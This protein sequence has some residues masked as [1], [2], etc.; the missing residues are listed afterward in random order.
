MSRYTIVLSALALSIPSCT[1]SPAVE[2]AACEKADDCAEGLSCVEKVCRRDTGGTRN[3]GGAEAGGDRALA[4]GGIDDRDGDDGTGGENGDGGGGDSGSVCCRSR[5]DCAPTKWCDVTACTC[6]SMRTCYSDYECAATF[7]CNPYRNVCECYTNDDCRDWPGGKTWCSNDTFRCEVPGTPPCDLDCERECQECVDGA[8]RFKEGM[9]CCNW[10]DCHPPRNTCD[11]D[12]HVC[13]QCLDDDYCR[14][15]EYCDQLTSTCVT[16]CDPPCD[17]ATAYC[18]PGPAPACKPKKP[19]L[20]APCADNPD[21][22]T[23]EGNLVCP[24]FLPRC[25]LRCA[26]ESDCQGL[27]C[28][29]ESG[30]CDCGDQK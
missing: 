13:V 5:E 26:D 4:D 19:K 24:V 1:P 11:E 30:M 16:R 23:A 15:S 7:V 22:V 12:R 17:A 8:C 21:C 27:R 28:H 25:T 18:D 6:R 14:R 10:E 2:G 29:Y 3:D 9:D 20:C